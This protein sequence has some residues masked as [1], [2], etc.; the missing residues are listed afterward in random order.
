LALKLKPAKTGYFY[1]GREVKNMK[2]MLKF[3]RLKL[4]EEKGEVSV[5][6]ALVA[7]VMAIIII[8]AFLPGVRD[9]LGVAID[10][11]S[12]LITSAGT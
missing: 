12:A 3:L 6:W 5:E 8:G 10:R 11:I 2:K 1:P 9:A 4:R 7:V